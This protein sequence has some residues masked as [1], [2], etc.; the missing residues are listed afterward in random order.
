MKSNRKVRKDFDATRA[1]SVDVS[2]CTEEEKKEVQQ[3]FFD[4]GI[5]WQWHGSEYQFLDAVQYTNKYASGGVQRHL[6]HG[7]T[8]EECNMTAKE[9]LDLVYEPE[10]QGHVH[11]ELM[12]QYAEDAKTSKTPWKLWQMKSA[13]GVWRGCEAHPVWVSSTVYRRKPKTHIVHGVEIPDLRV[14]PEPGDSYYLIDPTLTELT[15]L[16]LFEGDT[17]DQL[18]VERGLTYQDTEEGKQAAI[19]HAKA[20]LGI[21]QHKV[22]NN[23]QKEYYQ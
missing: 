19:L 15:N 21:A 17:V 12:A 20:M 3:A 2:A 1:Y 6:L 9:F 10:Y 14:T 8:T 18:W 7:S 23:R 22:H 16:Y 4:V 5:F 11:A 13:D